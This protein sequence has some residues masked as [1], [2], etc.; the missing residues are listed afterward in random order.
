[1]PGSA[2]DDRWGGGKYAEEIATFA[3]VRAPGVADLARLLLPGAEFAGYSTINTVD[4]SIWVLALISTASS[5]C[6]P[7]NPLRWGMAC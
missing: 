2:S 4:S 1:M 5:A 6:A 7:A 3:G